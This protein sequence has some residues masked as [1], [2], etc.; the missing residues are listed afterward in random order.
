MEVKRTAVPHALLRDEHIDSLF[1][2]DMVHLDFQQDDVY[3]EFGFLERSSIV[4][5]K[6]KKPKRDS[7]SLTGPKLCPRISKPYSK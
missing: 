1:E 4:S 6:P 5:P 2:A 3:S 7:P